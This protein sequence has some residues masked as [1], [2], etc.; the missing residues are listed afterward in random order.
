VWRVTRAYSVL[1]YAANDAP[2]KSWNSESPDEVRFPQL[3]TSS[4]ITISFF[5]LKL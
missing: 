3:F 4:D 5:A 1:S 2:K